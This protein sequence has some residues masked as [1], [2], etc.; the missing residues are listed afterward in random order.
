MI[1][2]LY[3]AYMEE[4]VVPEKDSSIRTLSFGEWIDQLEDQGV[5]NPEEDLDIYVKFTPHIKPWRCVKRVSR[6]YYYNPTIDWDEP[7]EFVEVHA[8]P[9]KIK[10]MEYLD[11]YILDDYWA[12][13]FE[14]FPNTV[15]E[16]RM[17]I[18]MMNCGGNDL[19][20]VIR[21]IRD[22]NSGYGYSLIERNIMHHVS[23]HS[24]SPRYKW[25]EMGGS[26]QSQKNEQQG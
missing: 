20:E 12:R 2:K 17:G 8:F 15:I 14:L 3:T 5:L 10:G 26:L 25:I 1:R 19:K 13:K 22:F 4:V 18:P 24:L 6:S 7:N 11:T 16:G 9:V 21:E 23:H